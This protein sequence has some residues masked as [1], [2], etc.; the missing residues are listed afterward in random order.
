M[1]STIF[2]RQASNVI[3][4]VCGAATALACGPYNPI[5]PTPSFFELDPHGL[6]ISAYSTH[7]NLKLWQSLTSDRIPLD[8]IYQAVY[9][10][11]H[12][13]FYSRIDYGYQTDDNKF[14]TYINNSGDYEIEVF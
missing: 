13:E 3:F 4:F 6:N 1:K 8:D 10:D 14:Y 5:I 2:L 12:D 11:S 9:K 7:E